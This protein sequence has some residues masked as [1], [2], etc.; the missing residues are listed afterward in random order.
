M[1]PGP[2][3]DEM[4]QYQSTKNA[5][6]HILFNRHPKTAQYQ[7]AGRRQYQPGSEIVDVIQASDHGPHLAY[8]G[9]PQSQSQIEQTGQA[10]RHQSEPG[11]VPDILIDIRHRQYADQQGAGRNGRHPVPKI[12]PRKHGAAR[13]KRRD[14]QGF[15]QGQGNHPH[16]SCRAERSP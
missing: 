10:K 7:D 12:N 8:P 15:P 3:L 13:I 5:D 11:H 2:S 14:S 6:C 4:A 16:G 1:F 9:Q